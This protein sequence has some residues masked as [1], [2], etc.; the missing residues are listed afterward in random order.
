MKQDIK[1]FPYKNKQC[2]V[3]TRSFNEDTE[4]VKFMNGE[5]TNFVKKLKSQDGKNIWIAGGGELIHS[6]M[7]E[8]LVDELIITVAPILLGH[9]IPLFKEGEDQF[10][11]SLKGIRTFNQFV[12]LYYTVK[13]Q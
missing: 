5:I 4:D 7:K 9:G 2:Y 6:F 8:K 10:N 11:L 12:E 1:E 3:F 13:K